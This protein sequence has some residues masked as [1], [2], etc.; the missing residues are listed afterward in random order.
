MVKTVIILLYA[1]ARKAEDRG[2]S[3]LEF[4]LEGRIRF[5]EAKRR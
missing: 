5:R 3:E 2:N 1:Q 4:I